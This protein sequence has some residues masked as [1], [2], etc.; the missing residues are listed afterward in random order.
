MSF[1]FEVKSKLKDWHA[2]LV[3]ALQRMITSDLDIKNWRE[4]EC[5][6]RLLVYKKTGNNLGESDIQVIPKARIV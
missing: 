3:D 2:K 1:V 6:L 5:R 4:F